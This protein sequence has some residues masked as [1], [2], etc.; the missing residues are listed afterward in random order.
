MI[1]NHL[2]KRHDVEWWSLNFS[3]KFSNDPYCL[4]IDTYV[5][6][7]LL[8]ASDCKRVDTELMDDNNI[9]QPTNDLPCVLRYSPHLGVMEYR[10]NYI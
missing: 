1:S 4:Y 7:F 3:Q 8:V 2:F 10:N 6:F 9:P 5:F